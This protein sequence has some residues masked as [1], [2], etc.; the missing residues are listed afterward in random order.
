MYSTQPSSPRGAHPGKQCHSPPCQSACQPPGTPS[1]SPRLTGRCCPAFASPPKIHLPR[2]LLPP[3]RCPSGGGT[4]SAAH[5]EAVEVHRTGVEPPLTPLPGVNRICACLFSR[6]RG[7]KQL[8]VPSGAPG[9]VNRRESVGLGG[10]SGGRAGEVG[11]IRGKGEERL[12]EVAHHQP[13]QPRQ[14]LPAAPRRRRTPE[15]C[16]GTVLLSRPNLSFQ[17]PL[18]RGRG[19]WGVEERDPQS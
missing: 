6:S 15:G 10:E 3:V 18:P 12:G 11:R 9:R 1:V 16:W 5:R 17:H 7:G 14:C 13:P 2:P 4:D 8:G 19:I